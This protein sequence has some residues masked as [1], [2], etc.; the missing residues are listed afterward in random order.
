MRRLGVLGWSKWHRAGP[1]GTGAGDRSFSCGSPKPSERRR[2]AWD[3]ACCV[4]LDLWEHWPCAFPETRVISRQSW[5]CASHRDSVALHLM[6]TL[7]FPWVCTLNPSPPPGTP[8]LSPVSTLVSCCTGW[9]C[10]PCHP[11]QPHREGSPPLS[12]DLRSAQGSG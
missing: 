4:S 10:K 5:P 2:A 6:P 9:A 12:S 7:K 8:A 11:G 1:L 3:S